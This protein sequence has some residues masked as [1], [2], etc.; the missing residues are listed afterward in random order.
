MKDLIKFSDDQVEVAIFAPG[1]H[2]GGAAPYSPADLQEIADTYTPGLHEAPNV[3]G[4]A[5]ERKSSDPA[6]GYAS[7]LFVRDGLLWARLK[8]VPEQFREW[9]RQGFWKKRSI[10]VYTDFKGTGKKYLRAIAWLGAEPPEVKGLPDVVFAENGGPVEVMEFEEQREGRLRRA[11]EAL[12]AVFAEEETPAAEAPIQALIDRSAA[13]EML[14]RIKW[15]SS[16]EMYRIIN[17]EMAPDEKKAQL[18]ALFD[19]LKTLIEQGSASLIATFAERSKPMAGPTV[20]A[21]TMT[22]EQLKEHD[23]ALIQKA[24]V[25]FA[26]K[27]DKTV[28]DKVKAGLAEISAQTRRTG[29]KVFCERLKERGLAPALVDDTGLALILEKLDFQ[30]THTFAE[31]AGPQ[32]L[33]SAIE[34]FVEKVVEAG[35]ANTL[36]VPQGEVAGGDRTRVQGDAKARAMA[37]FAEAPEFYTTMGLK[38][39]DFER[40]ADQLE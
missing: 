20:G 1:N 34:S 15:I 35:K 36:I 13:M 5:E 9:V 11:W 4:H 2:H 6:Y 19:E 32:S 21:I 30:G 12:R 29:V 39:E 27:Q 25:S 40:I 18:Q 17:E 37:T 28:D 16:D 24:L 22:P 3:I 33:A 31:K 10:E 26:E 23:E 14:E 38:V 8:Q 7:E